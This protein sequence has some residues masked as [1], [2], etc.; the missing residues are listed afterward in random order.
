M[1]IDNETAEAIRSEIQMF[2]EFR[3][4]NPD[5][6]IKNAGMCGCMGP[7]PECKCAK[8]RRLV[9]AFLDQILEER[10]EL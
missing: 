4:Y 7:Q 9:A 8:R 5:A 6:P 10:G 3:K 1:N 2:H